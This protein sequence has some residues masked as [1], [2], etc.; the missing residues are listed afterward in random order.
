MRQLQ[1]L[2]VA[3]DLAS[4]DAA[5]AGSQLVLPPRLVEEGQGE[6]ALAVGDAHLE[7]RAATLAHRPRGRAH[8]LGDDR[9]VLVDRQFGERG[10]LAA[11]GVAPRIVREQ[12]ADRRETEVLLERRSGAPAQQRTQ[13]L[14]E[15]L[16]DLGRAH[17]HPRRLNTM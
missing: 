3:A 5:H 13:L 4:E 6:E 2:L 1:R 16:V 9:G 14:V 17:S 11:P 15:H 10:Q 12:V 7:D 8:H